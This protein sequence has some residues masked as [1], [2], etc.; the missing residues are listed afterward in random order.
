MIAAL[1]E[2]QLDTRQKV[3]AIAVA[4]AILIAVV[5]LVRRRKLREEYSF[6]WLF[7]AAVLMAM[8]LEPTI[9]SWFA[10]LVGAKEGPSAL[11]FGALMFL[12]LLSLLITL[13]L[14]RLTFRTKTLTRVNALADAELE[15]LRAEIAELRREVARMREVEATRARDGVA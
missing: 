14:S 3:V 12:M 7:T 9:L 10:E 13:R 8:A 5:E 15:E 11:F 2:T 4:V 6:I 1:L